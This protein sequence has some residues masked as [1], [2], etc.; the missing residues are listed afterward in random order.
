MHRKGERQRKKGRDGGGRR[1]ELEK[2]G[3]KGGREKDKKRKRETKLSP[4]LLIASVLG[5]PN[6]VRLPR[7]SLSLPLLCTEPRGWPE[8]KHFLGVFS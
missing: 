6:R 4:S 8:A 5:I 1:K 3:N 2:E 7:I